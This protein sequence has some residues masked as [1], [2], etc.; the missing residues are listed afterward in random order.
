LPE[1][2]LDRFLLK[3]IIEYPSELEEI[4]IMKSSSVSSIDKVNKVLSKK[5]ILSLQKLIE[6]EIFIDDKVYNYVKDL[7]FATRYPLNY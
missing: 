6:D 4:E 5:D 1:A 7:V 3:V 2:Q